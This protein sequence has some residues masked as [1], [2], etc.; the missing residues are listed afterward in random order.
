[1]VTEKEF[2]AS[3]ECFYENIENKFCTSDYQK[4]YAKIQFL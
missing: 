1:M 3:I 4:L 2:F